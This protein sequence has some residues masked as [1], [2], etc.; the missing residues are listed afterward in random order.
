MVD[1]SFSDGSSNAS[2]LLEFV[3]IPENLTFYLPEDRTKWKSD[4]NCIV[5]STEMGH[6]LIR[7][8]KYYC[9]F[10]YRAVCQQHSG[11]QITHPEEPR[12]QRIC[13]YCYQN[14]MEKYYYDRYSQELEQTLAD[15]QTIQLEIENK[16]EAKKK[17]HSSS[18]S[19]EEEISLF[20][21]ESASKLTKLEGNCE[22][23][24]LQKEKLQ[25]KIN[26]LKLIV[27]REESSLMR[28]EEE[29]ELLQQELCK[30]ES[31]RKE[32][33]NVIAQLKLSLATAHDENNRLMRL[34]EPHNNRNKQEPQKLS[35][36]LQNQIKQ[37]NLEMKKKQK[38]ADSFIEQIHC[39][40][41]HIER[42][43]KR[44]EELGKSSSLNAVNSLT[45]D[46]KAKLTD[47]RLQI[48]DQEF[49]LDRLRMQFKTKEIKKRK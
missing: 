30:H 12:P 24:A 32:K 8:K 26:K 22:E 5:C 35:K 45:P 48:Q 15:K 18:K 49:H 44:L 10:C 4:L 39:Y 33:M 16:I 36:K 17:L 3:P 9:K 46:E 13:E 14:A 1:N 7:K 38:E 28:R 2:S 27:E 19:L 6:G 25:G 37:L 34:H 31:V 41:S 29:I 42:T 23:I 21:T 47:L 43:D 40:E 11:L 20:K